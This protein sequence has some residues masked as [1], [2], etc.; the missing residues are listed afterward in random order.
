VRTLTVELAPALVEQEM[1]TPFDGL[2]ELVGNGLDADA[3]NVSV[4]LDTDALDRV[5]TVR[6]VDDGDGMSEVEAARAFGKYG[7]SWKRTGGTTGRLGRRLRG[8]RG[9]GRYGAFAIGSRVRWTSYDATAVP[10][11]V[12][13][14]SGTLGNLLSFGID[15]SPTGPAPIN[16]SSPRGTT[17]RV[18][19]ANAAAD[20][21]QAPDVRARLTAAFA[22]YLV[23]YPDVRVELA[24]TP[25]DPRTTQTRVDELAVDD[26]S[27]GPPAILRVVEWIDKPRVRDA[28]QVLV[29]CDGRGHALADHV[30]DLPASDLRWTAYLSWSGFDGE[31]PSLVLGENAPGAAGPMVAAGLAA[32]REHLRAR[33]D[34]T[35]SRLLQSW[36][37][38]GSY[39]YDAEPADAVARAERDLFD[40]VAVAAA[41]VLVRAD[42]RGRRFSLR[43]VREALESNPTS[44]GRILRDVLDLT[45]DQIEDLGALLERTSLAK[46]I[47]S[48]TTVAAR[49]DTL[50]GL[51]TLLFDPE[52]RRELLEREQLQPI[53]ADEAWIFGDE[54]TLTVSE[55]GLTGVLERHIAVLGRDDD[56][57]AVTPVTSADGKRRRV[58]LM[59]TRTIDSERV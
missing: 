20:R 42:A 48:A 25:L 11:T 55:S 3:L 1:G 26:P 8:S 40:D 19:D 54:Y 2:V 31:G 30:D 39:P 43:L 22:G 18:S 44:L 45:D 33:A 47:T 38:E 34:E 10:A 37:D 35:G 36:R 23:R 28:E 50:T 4:H 56:V 5:R 17:V 27:G 58:D 52:S 46:V 21:L 12:T 24:S 59:L 14:V 53:L 49:L 29:L 15:G 9:K 57:P 7:Q 16:E 51:E 41:P 6:V 32:L 13:V